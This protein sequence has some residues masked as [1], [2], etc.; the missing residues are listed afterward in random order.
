MENKRKYTFEDCWREGTELMQKDKYYNA[1]IRGSTMA[2]IKYDMALLRED[3]EEIRRHKEAY[4]AITEVIQA[5]LRARY[6]DEGNQMTEEKYKSLEEFI[7]M[8]KQKGYWHDVEV[9]P[10]AKPW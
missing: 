1:L 5:Y 6:G 9:R 2:K 3:F 4:D 8:L 7:E 10:E